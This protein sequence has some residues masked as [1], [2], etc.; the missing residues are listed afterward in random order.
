MSSLVGRYVRRRRDRK[1]SRQEEAATPVAEEIGAVESTGPNRWTQIT[2]WMADFGRKLVSR[3]GLALVMFLLALV[4]V[5]FSTQGL[6]SQND[7]RL[8]AGAAAG[9]VFG[10]IALCLGAPLA[11]I[12]LGA[13]ASR[14]V[15]WR[16]NWQRPSW[17]RMPQISRPQI[18]KPQIKLA[19]PS[20]WP[21]PSRQWLRPVVLTVLVVALGA[22][23]IGLVRSFPGSEP[24]AV[25]EEPVVA[26]PGVEASSSTVRVEVVGTPSPPGGQMVDPFQLVRR[27]EEL[28]VEKVTLEE[29]VA[30]LEAEV[31]VLEGERAALQDQ[32]AASAARVAELESQLGIA[33]GALSETVVE[34]ET[35]TTA[36][37]EIEAEAKA[38]T[39][40]VVTVAS[41]DTVWDLLEEELGQAPTW[42]QIQSV[43]DANDLV[44][45]GVNE[46]GLWIVLIQI[47]QTIDLTPGLASG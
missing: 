47:G 38:E 46:D 27:I 9:I 45:N 43:V 33:V 30:D 29:S 42:D 13:Y 22:A 24:T 23:Y 5:A 3:T 26:E 20:N 19:W 35:V 17:L 39:E 16:P 8:V 41:G 36:Q 12:N 15:R 28:E 34:A 14:I 44:D 7:G 11:G 32:L 6:V 10:V 25:V 31:A 40:H 21:R 18:Q 4:A 2:G 1:A 37:T